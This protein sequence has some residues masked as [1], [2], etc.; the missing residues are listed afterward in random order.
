MRSENVRRKWR[1]LL[2]NKQKQFQILV[3]LFSNNQRTMRETSESVSRQLLWNR[4]GLDFLESEPLYRMK[5]C[6]IPEA[7]LGGSLEWK[8]LPNMNSLDETDKSDLVTNFRFNGVPNKI[9]LLK[10]STEFWFIFFFISTFKSSNFTNF[11]NN[12]L[13]NVYESTSQVFPNSLSAFSRF[14]LLKI[15]GISE[16]V[17]SSTSQRPIL[18][19]R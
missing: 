14:P 8:K 13:I 11:K 4:V 19:P 2:E 12:K 3:L 17:T 10:T 1:D 15:V 9:F 16:S 18:E 6:G 7:F 5:K